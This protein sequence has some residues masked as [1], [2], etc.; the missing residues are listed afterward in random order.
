MFWTER[1]TDAL[2][3]VTAAT[4]LLSSVDYALAVSRR[5]QRHHGHSPRS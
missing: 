3:L 5:L 1:I 2:I 4:V